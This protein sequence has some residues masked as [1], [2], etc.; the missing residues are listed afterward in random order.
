MEDAKIFGSSTKLGG[1]QQQ[2]RRGQCEYNCEKFIQE[3]LVKKSSPLTAS[4]NYESP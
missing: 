3:N 2:D 4:V 1:F